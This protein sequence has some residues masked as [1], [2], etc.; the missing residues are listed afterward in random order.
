MGLDGFSMTNLGLHK[1]LTSAQMSNAAEV[2]ATKGTER[3]IKTV[4]DLS[5]KQRTKNKEFEEEDEIPVY[6]FEDDEKEGNEGQDKEKKQNGEHKKYTV[7]LNSKTQ[8]IELVDLERKMII[9]TISP[10][11]LIKLVSKLSSTSGILVNRKI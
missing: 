5:S 1:E 8:L 2:L 3:S 6:Y 9:E 10:N 7:K 4:D 11:D